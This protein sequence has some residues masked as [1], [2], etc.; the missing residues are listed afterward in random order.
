MVRFAAPDRTTAEPVNVPD[1]DQLSDKSPAIK[2]PLELAVASVENVRSDDP[3]AAA[4]AVK[5]A[6]A[7][8]ATS[9]VPAIGDD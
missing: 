4:C 3:V 2:L 9:A 7:V 6:V 1:V 8:K 5:V